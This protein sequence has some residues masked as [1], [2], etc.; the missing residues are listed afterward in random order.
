M[1]NTVVALGQPPKHEIKK[2]VLNN[3]VFNALK[4]LTVLMRKGLCLQAACFKGTLQRG[5][6]RE[7][8]AEPLTFQTCQLTGEVDEVLN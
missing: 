3:K 6:I 7:R 4:K 1:K 2:L 5:G 8:M